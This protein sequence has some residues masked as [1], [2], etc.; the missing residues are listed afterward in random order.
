[1]L[2]RKHGLQERR[3][4]EDEHLDPERPRSALDRGEDGAGG[5]VG[6][7]DQ[8]AGHTA[9]VSPPMAELWEPPD[10]LARR[11][12]SP[13]RGERSWRQT[14]RPRTRLWRRNNTPKRDDP[15]LFERNA[16]MTSVKDGFVRRVSCRWLRYVG[17]ESLHSPPS[18]ENRGR[19]TTEREGPH[20]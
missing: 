19:Q 2:R 10:D 18:T 17:R 9:S 1:M 12:L 15:N 11:D 3:I 8:T 14:L 7:N 6:Q 16:F 5:V 4:R 13:D 20:A